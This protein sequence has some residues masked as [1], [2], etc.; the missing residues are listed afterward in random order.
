MRHMLAA[1]NQSFVCACDEVALA[2]ALGRLIGD[3]AQRRTVGAANRR[4]AEADYGQ[5]DMF[6][7][8]GELVIR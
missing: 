4:K 3:P 6:R 1:E 2:D 8:Y 7:R 5:L